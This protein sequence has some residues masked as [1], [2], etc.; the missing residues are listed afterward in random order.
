M[1]ANTTQDSPSSNAIVDAIPETRIRVAEELLSNR[2]TAE[3][4]R[5]PIKRKSFEVNANEN[6]SQGVSLQE[7]ARRNLRG[8]G[9]SLEGNK[10]YVASGSIDWTERAGTGDEGRRRVRDRKAN[11][12][13]GLSRFGLLLYDLRNWISKRRRNPS[14]IQIWVHQ[15]KTVEG[16]FGSGIS[17][18]FVLHRWSFLLNV[19]LS[20]VWL[21]F[22]LSIGV[23]SMFPHFEV[24]VNPKQLNVTVTGMTTP[25][26]NSLASGR[27]GGEVFLDIFTGD[28]GFKNS[29]FFYYGYYTNEPF[30]TYRM[31]LAYIA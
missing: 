26:W 21:V 23:A 5:K 19:F 10:I 28:N 20:F 25:K 3:E 8:I 16:R 29:S 6:E 27:N 7:L 14:V 12:R 1:P 24:Q 11:E 17:S 2:R 13:A 4:L 31:D 22:V 9:M 30:P 15:L 18:Y